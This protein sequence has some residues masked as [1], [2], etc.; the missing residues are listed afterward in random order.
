M[1]DLVRQ[2]KVVLLFL[3][4]IEE[5][6]P[7]VLELFEREILKELRKVWGLLVVMAKRGPMEWHYGP[8]L[9]SY[10]QQYQLTLFPVQ[11]TQKQ[12]EPE[13]ATA[14]TAV[15][16][17]T[18]G[19]PYAN[20]W[21]KEQW[22][23]ERLHI[24]PEQW[25]AQND[26]TISA[27]LAHEIV[28][29]YILKG[30]EQEIQEAFLKTSVVRQF[31]T[32]MLYCLLQANHYPYSLSPTRAL[33]YLE[34]MSKMQKTG[35]LTW[36]SEIKGWL[37]EPAV[38]R[39]LAAFLRLNHSTAFAGLHK[40]ALDKYQEWFNGVPDDRH[41]FAI[42]R[43]YHEACLIVHRQP[44]VTPREVAY[45][46]RDLL[47]TCLSAQGAMINTRQLKNRMENDAELGAMVNLETLTEIL[48]ERIHV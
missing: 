29:E 27:K 46:L 20:E 34:L 36:D 4:H 12:T 37:M 17:L 3:D 15:Q 25:I 47:R 7:D 38:R 23:Q 28:Y 11:A 5:A 48:E 30:H 10:S 44:N 26:S 6:E 16:T 8:A 1:G 43:L 9:R 39:I 13:L 18:A 32:N 24:T 21:L 40:V 31:E 33:Y 2:H 45:K 42:E 14:A 35:L 41:L 19:L 22:N